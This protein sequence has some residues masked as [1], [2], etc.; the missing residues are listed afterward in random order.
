MTGIRRWKLKVE[1][2]M[3]F[4]CDYGCPCS[5]NAPPTYTTCEAAGAFHIAEGKYGDVPLDGLAWA[6]ASVWPGPVH[7]LNGRSVVYLDERASAEQRAALEAIATGK[8]GGPIGVFMSTLTAGIEVRSASIEFHLNGKNSWFRVPG[9]IDL[10]LGPI[11]N[12]VTGAEHRASALLPTGMMTRRE[13]FYSA[14][15]FTVGNGQFRFS[16]PGRNAYTFK[17]TWRG[18]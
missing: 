8:A 15:R 1:H 9:Q 13:D 5:F 12:P 16:Y 18:P 10:A 6:H 11:R 3:G 7:E 17:H 14:D 2:M 4:N